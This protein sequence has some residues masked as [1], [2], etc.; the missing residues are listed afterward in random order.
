MACVH[1]S[2][3]ETWYRAPRARADQLRSAGLDPTGASQGSLALSNFGS[4]YLIR[5]A[6]ILRSNQE[7][8]VILTFSPPREQSLGRAKM[9]N[10]GTTL[11]PARRP[12]CAVRPI[13]RVPIPVLRGGEGFK[14]DFVQY[15][16]F[17]VG[18]KLEELLE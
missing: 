3:S 15:K 8:D 10:L 6:T 4:G 2:A 12:G 9:A 14:G 1:H 17:A 18:Q 7:E 16:S 13:N 11:P 5:P